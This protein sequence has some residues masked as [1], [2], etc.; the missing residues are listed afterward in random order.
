MACTLRRGEQR[1]MVPAGHNGRQEEFDGLDTSELGFW[2]CPWHADGGVEAEIRRRMGGQSWASDSGIGPA[3][4]AEDFRKLTYSLAETEIVRYRRLG[5][6]CSLAMEEALGAVRPGYTEHRVAGLIC[7]RL[8]DHGVRPH[9]VLVAAGSSSC[10]LRRAPGRR[11][12]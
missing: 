4:L 3:P 1:Q 7:Q 6:D 10:R 12:R 9:V 2:S 8:Q 11:C 5:R